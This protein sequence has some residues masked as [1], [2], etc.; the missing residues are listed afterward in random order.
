MASH[1]TMSC[2]SD[3]E[4]VRAIFNWMT[5][6]RRKNIGSGSGVTVDV[7]NSSEATPLHDLQ[8]IQDKKNNDA[9]FF[10]HLSKQVV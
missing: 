4:R 8:S 5:S 2:S 6:V 3:L 7:E 1:L 10:F 9:H